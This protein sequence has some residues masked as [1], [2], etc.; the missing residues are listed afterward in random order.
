[1]KICIA[2]HGRFGE[3][4]VKSASMILGPLENTIT[5]S[6]LPEESGEEFYTKILN[7]LE[8]YKSEKFIFLVDLF[9][10]TPCNMVALVSRDYNIELVTGLN[11]PMFM[12]VYMSYKESDD[13]TSIAIKTCENSA[14]DVIKKFRKEKNCE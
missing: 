9:G 10:G 6:L 12:E 4:L 7:E 1:M 2:T 11:L 14:I 5:F 13:I 3:E 8:K